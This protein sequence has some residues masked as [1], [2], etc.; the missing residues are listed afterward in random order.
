MCQEQTQSGTGDGLN[1]EK[2]EWRRARASALCNRVA[3]A[4][5]SDIYSQ[6]DALREAPLGSKVQAQ[7][8]R[9]SAR[10]EIR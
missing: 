6:V 5:Y 8:P 10:S 9:E 2:G 4:I 1:L 3:G 7:G